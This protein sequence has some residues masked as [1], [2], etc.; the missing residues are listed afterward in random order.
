MTSVKKLKS[1]EINSLIKSFK[2]HGLLN[3]YDIVWILEQS[4]R[5]ARWE[6]FSTDDEN[7]SCL[8]KKDNYF[9]LCCEKGADIERFY[10]KIRQ[11]EDFFI[12]CYQGWVKNYFIEKV[13]N[14][15]CKSRS[16]YYV[17]QENFN[18]SKKNDSSL[19]KLDDIKLD[20]D[21]YSKELLDFLIQKQKI[22]GITEDKD[23]IAWAYVDTITKSIAEVYK[24]E[25]HPLKRRRGYGKQVLSAAIESLLK[26]E[27]IVVF[28][29]GIDNE[30]AV[31]MIKKLGFKE[32]GKE[33]RLR[34]IQQ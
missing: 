1:K 19:L 28:N 23:L 21:W 3:N 14:V 2:D 20:Q 25:V 31:N 16:Y 6:V 18:S 24:V 13:Y 32:Q 17:T 15:I 26:T 30:A 22:Y 27:D 34:K 9:W 7:L 33:F 10:K 12:H 29:V 11:Q 5:T 8:I 4:K